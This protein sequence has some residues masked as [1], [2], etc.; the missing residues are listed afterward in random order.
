MALRDG[1]EPSCRLPRGS[2]DTSRRVRGLHL[3]GLCSAVGGILLAGYSGQA[4][5]AMGDPMLLPS[6]AAVVVGGTKITGGEGAYSGTIVGVLVLTLLSNALT[7]MQSPEAL[8]MI[9]Y[10]GTILAMLLLGRSRAASA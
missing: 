3:V 8:K 7:L 6:I 10:G 9:I 5:Q 4:F 2:A 1:P